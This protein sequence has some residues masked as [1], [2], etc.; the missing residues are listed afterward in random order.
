MGCGSL[1][2]AGSQTRFGRGGNW[3]RDDRLEQATHPGTLKAGKSREVEYAGPHLSM[4][5]DRS[6]YGD[7][8]A[9]AFGFINDRLCCLCLY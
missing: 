4:T 1:L 3:L 5:D 2:A 6:E 8:R 7:V 9:V